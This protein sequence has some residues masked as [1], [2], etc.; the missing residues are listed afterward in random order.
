MNMSSFFTSL[1]YWPVL[2]T[3]ATFLLLV[4]QVIEWG[5]MYRS[6]FLRSKINLF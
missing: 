2:L 6:N 4:E 1:S 5:R 3:V